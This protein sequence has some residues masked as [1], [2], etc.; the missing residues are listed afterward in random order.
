MT[1]PKPDT[2]SSWVV[3]WSGDA[4]YKSRLGCGHRVEAGDPIHRVTDGD[5]TM[6]VCDR[7]L[8]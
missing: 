7:C 1:Q 8:P 6:Y 3:K 2:P 4:Q 5:E